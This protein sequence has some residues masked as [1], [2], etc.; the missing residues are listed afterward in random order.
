MQPV[1]KLASEHC[2]TLKGHKQTTRLR[3][4]DLIN[5]SLPANGLL[6][7]ADTDLQ[8]M[9][10][11]KVL[12]SLNCIS[13]DFTSS[14]FLTLLVNMTDAFVWIHHRTVLPKPD[15]NSH[16]SSKHTSQIHATEWK[17]QGYKTS[18]HLAGSP[19]NPGEGPL[20]S[21][22]PSLETQLGLI[23]PLTLMTPCS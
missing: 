8:L 17:N 4:S 20:E 7:T 12:K 6:F 11:F 23:N 2:F 1:K 13:S 21:P 19:W 22:D 16:A 9:S 18:C 14:L 15:H 3:G 10:H 5:S